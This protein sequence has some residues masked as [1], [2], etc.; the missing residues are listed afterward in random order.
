MTRWIPIFFLQI[1]GVDLKQ[2]YVWQVNVTKAPQLHNDRKLYLKKI[3]LG[4]VNVL[5]FGPGE[6]MKHVTFK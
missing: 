1:D 6:L 4:R 5:K 2:F 3:I